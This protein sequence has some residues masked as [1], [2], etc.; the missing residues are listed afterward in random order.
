MACLASSP[1][2]SDNQGSQVYGPHQP[3][4]QSRSSLLDDDM[5]TQAGDLDMLPRKPP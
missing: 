4:D 2:S 5:K 3:D 1:C